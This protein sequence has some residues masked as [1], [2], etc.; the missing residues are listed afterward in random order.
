MRKSSRNTVR[1]ILFCSMAVCMNVVLGS[2]ITFTH[3]PFL[4]LDSLGTIFIAVNFNMQYGILTGL[5]TNLLLGVIHGPLA[6]PFGLVSIVIA[7]VANLCARKN[8]LYKR[9]IIT[10]ILLALIG[11]LVSAPIRLILYGGF[12][13]L[14]RSITDAVVFSLQAAGW[15]TI[16]AA[17]WG[18][19][20]DGIFD[21]IISCLFVS[22]LSS[23]P[24]IKKKLESY[25]FFKEERN[26]WSKENS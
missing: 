13:G 1:V 4:F 2:I 23:L 11:S 21:K 25:H 5:C 18:A 9:A 14:H 17:Y 7:I 24:Q 16:I 22:W 10:G 12:G 26:E 20:T 8:F 19:V 15:K 6:L 3:I